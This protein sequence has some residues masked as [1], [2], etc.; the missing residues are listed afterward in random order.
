MPSISIATVYN[1]LETLVS[2]GLVKQVNIER[3][4]TRYCPNLAPHAHF[5]CRDT[6]RV[7]DVPVP[8]G[9]MKDLA[10]VLPGEYSADSVELVFR[11]HLSKGNNK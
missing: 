1:C 2:C 3:E 4:P 7:Y 5:H 11:G 10:K 6:G 9:M 8:E